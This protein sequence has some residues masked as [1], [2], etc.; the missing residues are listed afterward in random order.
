MI[1][2]ILFIVWLSI[3]NNLHY[4]QKTYFTDTYA[5][6][7]LAKKPC[8][9]KIRS[10][11]KISS[12]TLSLFQNFYPW[13]IH[14]LKPLHASRAKCSEGLWKAVTTKTSYRY[15]Q[16][17]WTLGDWSWVL[18]SKTS[19]PIPKFP[20]ILKLCKMRQFSNKQTMQ[21][22]MESFR[23]LKLRKH[24]QMLSFTYFFLK[25]F[26]LIQRLHL[27]QFSGPQAGVHW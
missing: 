9:K 14:C 1:L 24:L 19:L 12:I 25:Y 13:Q 7:E 17:F 8:K 16:N 15:V 6:L 11:L 18:N 26:T 5:T 3:C 21:T 23:C 2:W 10:L 27:A 22:V 20:L 4:E